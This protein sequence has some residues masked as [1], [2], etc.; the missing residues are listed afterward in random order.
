MQALILIRGRI[1]L[2]RELRRLI[3]TKGR[4]HKA[5]YPS[6]LLKMVFVAKL[7]Y[8]T[9][10]DTYIIQIQPATRPTEDDNAPQA[11]EQKRHMRDDA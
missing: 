11:G 1:L 4:I 7:L 5:A 2:S 6:V 3:N 8:T 9:T 10:V